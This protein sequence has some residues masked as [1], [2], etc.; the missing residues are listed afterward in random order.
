MEADR[1]GCRR[2]RRGRGHIVDT[3]VWPERHNLITGERQLASLGCGVTAELA[4]ITLAINMAQ[5][6]T[7]TPRAVGPQSKC[8]PPHAAT[9]GTPLHVGSR[10]VTEE[11]HDSSMEHRWHLQ[12][13]WLPLCWY[14][15]R[16]LSDVVNL[17]ID[18]RRRVR[19]Q[20]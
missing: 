9:A 6:S 7:E 2:G 19:W 12:R 13:R 5:A 17:R 20:E 14:G 15:V 16:A 8:G 1:C 3:P 18:G 4:I 11:L 10:I